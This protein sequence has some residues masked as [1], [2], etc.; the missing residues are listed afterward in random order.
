MLVE[1]GEQRLQQKV[2]DWDKRRRRRR[3][4]AQVIK[5]LRSELK[6]LGLEEEDFDSDWDEIARS[7]YAI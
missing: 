7:R 6:K 5:L 3:T 4:E 1:L 2:A